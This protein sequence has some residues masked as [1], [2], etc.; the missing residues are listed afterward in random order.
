[1]K[2]E[3]DIYAAPSDS[4]PDAE[5]KRTVSELVISCY[6]SRRLKRKLSEKVAGYMHVCGGYY[7][8]N[9]KDTIYRNLFSTTKTS[10]TG[11]RWL[12]RK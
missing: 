10:S 3:E 1:M 11:F 12:L 6:Q 4:R 2:K 5:L 8:R 9:S 7:R